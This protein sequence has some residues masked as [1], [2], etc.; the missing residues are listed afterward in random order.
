MNY[1]SVSQFAEKYGLSARSVRYQCKTGKIVG[2]FRTGK[3][4]N[5]PLGAEILS[6]KM[7]EFPLLKRLRMEKSAHFKGGIYHRIQIEL[8]YN[9]NHLEGSQLTEEQ[10][11][12]IFETH[13][14]GATECVRVDDILETLNHF[15]CVDYVIDHAT[16]KLTEM[17]VKELH[18]IL[19]SNTSDSQK[20][21]FAVG[22]Y[23]K[24]P[25]EVGGE[26]TALPKE[27]HSRVQKLLKAYHSLKKVSID[28][29]L[30]FHVEFERIH[31]FQDG[32]GR[33]GRLLLFWQ[34]LQSGIIPF[35]ITENLRYFYYRG[36]ENWGKINGFLRD[37]CLSAQDEFREKLKRLEVKC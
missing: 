22:E 3:M 16:E 36:L 25:N 11:R 7:K 32:N 12:F 37:T 23:K 33:V 24:L 5:I 9:S 35:I 10:T 21:W 6:K 2:A 19:K 4:W 26:R 27:V 30:Q 8:T 31:P 14:L 1:L 20:E 28:D 18:R 29:I 13:T 17:H 15:R 34:C